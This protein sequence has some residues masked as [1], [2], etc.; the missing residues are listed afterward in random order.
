MGATPDLHDRRRVVPV[1]PETVGDPG[2]LDLEGLWTRYDDPSHLLAEVGQL[3]GQAATRRMQEIYAEPIKAE[4]ITAR[5]QQMREAGVTVAG[6]VVE[7]HSVAIHGPLNIPSTIPFHASQLYAKNIATFLLHLAK[8]GTV[9]LDSED[10]IVR[11]TLLTRD[12]GVVHP[13]IKELLG[14][15]NKEA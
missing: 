2:V 14:G 8:G 10:E 4:L 12:G 9:N 3:R 6:E 7:H 15:A 13:R 11:E 5:L 1:D